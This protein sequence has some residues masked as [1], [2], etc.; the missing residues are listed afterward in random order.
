MP[1]DDSESR[2]NTS[3]NPK[4]ARHRALLAEAEKYTVRSE[5]TVDNFLDWLR[6]RS[7]QDFLHQDDEGQS[8]RER[9]LRTRLAKIGLVLHRSRKRNL[10]GSGYGLYHVIDKTTGHIIVNAPA[11]LT[12]IEQWMHDRGNPIES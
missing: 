10:L 6:R 1:R 2:L 9:R 5:R 11:Y 8:R 7:V 12:G 4:A 3:S